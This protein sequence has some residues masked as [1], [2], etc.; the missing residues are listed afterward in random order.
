M[1]SLQRF[2]W[3]KGGNVASAGWQVTPCD[4]GLVDWWFAGAAERCVVCTDATVAPLH[5][6]S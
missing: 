3:Y 1:G 6:V 4:A 5:S 2:G